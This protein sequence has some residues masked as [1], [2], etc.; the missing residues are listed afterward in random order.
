[1]RFTVLLSAL[2][3]GPSVSWAQ[4]YAELIVEATVSLP[5]EERAGAAVVVVDLDGGDVPLAVEI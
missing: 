5:E 1:M 3:I 2:L 4:S